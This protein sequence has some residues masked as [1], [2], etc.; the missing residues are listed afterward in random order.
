MESRAWTL[1]LTG[2]ESGMVG[3]PGRHFEK[4]PLSYERVTV[5]ER[6]PALKRIAELEARAKAVVESLRGS[7]GINPEAAKA[8]NELAALLREE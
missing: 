8:I 1:L 2:D 7:G 6:D 4:H 5:I 3:G